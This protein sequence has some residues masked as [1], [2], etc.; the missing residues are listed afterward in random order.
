MM[1]LLL[2]CMSPQLAQGCRTGM[3]ALTESIGG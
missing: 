2:R 1:G 3:S